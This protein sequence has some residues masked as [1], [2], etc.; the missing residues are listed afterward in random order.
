MTTESRR[1][2]RVSQPS[3]TPADAVRP[4][5]GDVIV[6]RESA[7]GGSYTIRQAPGD[8]QLYVPVR[9]HAIQLARRFASKAAVNLWYSF[10]GT[11]RLLEEYRG[12]GQRHA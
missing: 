6:S 10:D 2:V 9:D 3:R 1:A 12:K 7:S 8:V 4:R 11:D 5:H